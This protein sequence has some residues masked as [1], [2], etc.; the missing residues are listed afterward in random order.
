[1]IRGP[2]FRRG[3]GWGQDCPGAVWGAEER[4]EQLQVRL[5][6]AA[7]VLLD[8]RS[9]A[10]FEIHFDV[11]DLNAAPR[12]P[13]RR[14]GGYA[15]HRLLFGEVFG[16]RRP[17][18]Y[19]QTYHGRIAPA[20]LAVVGAGQVGFS[21]GMIGQLHVPGRGPVLVSRLNGDY[22]AGM[23]PTAW[24]SFRLLSVV[25]TTADGLPMVGADSEHVATLTDGV[26]T[27]V[28]DTRDGTLLVRL[29]DPGTPAEEVRME[30]DLAPFGAVAP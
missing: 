18:Y 20:Y 29:A 7:T 26:L 2:L 1:M 30:Y 4:G 25:G 17:A 14:V 23:H 9:G 3:Q 11:R 21:G 13:A 15:T 16:V 5:H 10:A 24:R 12:G 27:T 28:G 19:C 8:H 22:G 6:D